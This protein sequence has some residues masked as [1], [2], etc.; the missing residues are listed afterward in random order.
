MGAAFHRIGPS[1]VVRGVPELHGAPVMASDLRGSACLVLAGLAAHGETVIS[2]VYHLDR[3]YHRLED[4]YRRL[5]ATIERFNEKASDP[6]QPAA[7]APGAPSAEA[8]GAPSAEV[9]FTSSQKIPT[10]KMKPSP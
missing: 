6:E 4:R 2:R 7:E 3:G 5:G 9:E 8:P 10:E 1:V